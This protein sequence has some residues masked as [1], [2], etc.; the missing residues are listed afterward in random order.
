M[1]YKRQRT[2]KD[3]RIPNFQ[4]EAQGEKYNLLGR[5]STW[6]QTLS[7][8]DTSLNKKKLCCPLHVCKKCYHIASPTLNEVKKGGC[9]CHQD[10]TWAH[11]KSPLWLAN[12]KK[13]DLSA[14]KLHLHLQMPH[15]KMLAKSP[16]TFVHLYFVSQN[17]GAWGMLQCP[18]KGTKLSITE[19]RCPS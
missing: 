9:I 10:F 11:P 5:T 17:R 4:R 19:Q 2:W 18:Q 14:L 8:A 3:T 12:L 15:S 13:D 6:R 1:S 16:D 7:L